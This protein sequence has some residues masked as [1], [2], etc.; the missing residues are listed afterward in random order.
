MRHSKFRFIWIVACAALTLTLFACGAGEEANT[1]APAGDD[2]GAADTAPA[3]GDAEAGEIGEGYDAIADLQEGDATITG[4][5]RY[6]GTPP[7]LP[8][9]IAA[10]FSLIYKILERKYGFDEFN[11]WF[12]AGG[13]RGL[14]RGLWRLGDVRLIDGVLVHGSARMVAWLATVGRR[15]QS[16]FIYH[17]AFTM[18]IGVLILVTLLF[19]QS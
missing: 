17:Y 11:D 19:V 15:I 5:V 4:T 9:V 2:A 8:A 16:G 12:F 3:A 6:A 13:M 14:G 7:N 18:I 1:E 10:R